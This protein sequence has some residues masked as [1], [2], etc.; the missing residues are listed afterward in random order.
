MQ[1]EGCIIDVECLLDKVK[2]LP[3]SREKE[4]SVLK[5]ETVKQCLTARVNNLGE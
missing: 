5:L 4:V 3:S 1:I 2:H